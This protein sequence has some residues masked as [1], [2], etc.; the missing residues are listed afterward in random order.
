MREIARQ[1]MGFFPTQDRIVAAVARLLKPATD[2]HG[3]F[4]ILDAGCGTGQALHD[5]RKNLLPHA[6]ASNVVLLGIESDKN[7]CHQAAQLLASG[8]GGGTALWSAIED[9]TIDQPASLLW[10]NP[11]YDRIRGAGRTETALFSRVKEWPAR[12]SGIVMMIVPDYVLADVDVGLAIAVERDFE[13]LGL[14]RYPE[15]EY[16]DFKQCVLLARRRE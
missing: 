9:A 15:P 14:W 7:R 4:V 6:P 13:L 11:P 2:A 1:K 10:F 16:Q 5:L 3:Q 12:G 8:P